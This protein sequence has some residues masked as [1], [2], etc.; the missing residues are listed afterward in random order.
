MPEGSKHILDWRIP[1]GGSGMRLPGCPPGAPMIRTRG[2]ALV[3]FPATSARFRQAA[4][5]P[6]PACAHARTQG[7]DVRAEAG[8]RVRVQG[9]GISPTGRG[10]GHGCRPLGVRGIPSQDNHGRGG[11]GNI[12]AGE[13]IFGRERKPACVRRTGATPSKREPGV[14]G[15]SSRRPWKGTACRTSIC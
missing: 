3:P 14:D 6:L 10:L 11:K 4:Q 2:D 8:K 12:P 1:G 13:E 9:R 5:A 15:A 7:G